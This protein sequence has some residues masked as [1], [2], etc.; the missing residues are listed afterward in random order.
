M[1]EINKLLWGAVLIFIGIIIGLNSLNIISINLLFDGWW[2]LFIIVPSLINLITDREKISNIIGLLVGIVLLLACNDIITFGLISKLFVP[3][4]LVLIGIYLILHDRFDSKIKKEIKRL[5]KDSK[6]SDDEYSAIFGSTSYN[7][8]SNLN[9]SNFNAI[10]GEVNVDL[11]S[12]NIEEDIA[13]SSTA[14]FG[15]VDIKVPKD[16]NVKVVGTP[17]FASIDNKVKTKDC[18]NTI[19]INCVALFGGVEIHE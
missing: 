18:K 8:I 7:S 11:T 4:L 15:S 10:F 13:I 3:T 6:V 17:V 12:N 19:F 2:T 9:G 14:I 1:K 5:K 16:V